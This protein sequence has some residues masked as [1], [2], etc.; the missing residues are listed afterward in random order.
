M[1]YLLRDR[2]IWARS[3]AQYIATKGWNPDIKADLSND[4]GSAYQRAYNAQ[5]HPQNFKP[6][7]EAIEAIF[8]G[9]GWIK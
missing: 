8:T 4:L 9:L 5:W 3:Y 1:D 6:I 7:A 2:E